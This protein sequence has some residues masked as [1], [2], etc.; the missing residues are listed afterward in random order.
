MPNCIWQECYCKS[1]QRPM[2]NIVSRPELSPLQPSTLEVASFVGRT[3]KNKQCRKK[4]FKIKSFE[5]KKTINSTF[6][7]SALKRDRKTARQR[8]RKIE[9]E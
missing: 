5:E 9:R 3:L 8:L 1:R 4:I 7:S 6:A 2:E